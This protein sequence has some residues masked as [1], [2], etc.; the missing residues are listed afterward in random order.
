MNKPKIGFDAYNEVDVGT[1]GKVGYWGIYEIDFAAGKVYNLVG[2]QPS[3][4]SIGNITYSNTNPD[5]VA[6]NYIDPTGKFDTYVG[7]FDKG[8]MQAL[9]IPNFKTSTGAAIVDAE[10]PTFSPDDAKLCLSS[11]ALNALLFYDPQTS[12]LS[13]VTFQQPL[14][15]PRW[16][17]QGGKVPSSAESVEIPTAFRLHDNYPNPFNPSTKI[18]YEVPTRSHVRLAV[19]DILGQLVRTLVNTDQSNGRFSAVWDGTNDHGSQLA[20]GMYIYR[21]EA[22]D[23]SGR[24]TVLSRKMLFLK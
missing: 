19:Y 5:L 11:P 10:R 16:F 22:A 17:I 20:S 18:K 1:S 3:N 7:N 8:Q 2:S 9:N 12:G 21:L 15:N 14:Y 6:F 24:S 23:G 13:A 4:V